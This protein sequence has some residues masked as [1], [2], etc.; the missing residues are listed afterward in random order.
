[1]SKKIWS[2]TT[3]LLIIIMSNTID[4]IK[5]VEAGNIMLDISKVEFK[6]DKNTTEK[7]IKNFFP[8]LNNQKINIEMLSKKIQYL[9]E[10]SN[11]KIEAEF[12]P[13]ENNSYKV[14]VIAK[15]EV[16]DK[17][18]IGLSN[19]GNVNTGRWKTA[20]NYY[21]KN[22]TNNADS[23]SLSFITSPHNIEN[24]YQ[25]YS[26]YNH[27]FPSLGDNLNLY[28]SYS[29]STLGTVAT[30]GNIDIFAHG[31]AEN[32]GVHYYRN[33]KYSSTK[34][35]IFD[36]GF[37]YKHYKGGHEF[38]YGGKT[39]VFNNYDI[40]NKSAS[41]TYSNFIRNKVYDF[42]YS[43]SYLR[44]LGGDEDAF[45]NY[46]TNAEI[47]YNIIQYNLNYVHRFNTGYM[48]LAKFNGQFTRDNLITVEQL[49]A[50]GNSTVCG[51]KEGSANGDYGYI[52]NFE[53]YTPEI[54]KDQRIV[55]FTDYASLFNNTYNIGERN[56]RL[57]SVGIGY[58]MWQKNGWEISINYAKNLCNIGVSES[59]IQ[60]W[61]INITKF[62]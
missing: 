33:L 35:T 8:E 50:G 57:W 53:L 15:K 28:Y 5:N 16:S 4:N 46:R 22:I 23:L 58:R 18:Y 41:I 52:G 62:F 21:N 13:Q 32:M 37:D 7:E 14:T 19:T 20:F 1:M 56:K 43:I 25:I 55:L 45:N 29:N 24:V 44:G 2:M 3:L 10:N 54:L 38:N 40:I 59:S 51:Y 47:N 30:I 11:I 61:N 48:L 9:N 49:G 17:F 12:Q 42:K 31:S 39:W 36:I 27:F 34:K 6:L 26:G 60:P